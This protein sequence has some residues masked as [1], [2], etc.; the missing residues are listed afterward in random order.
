[1]PYLQFKSPNLFPEQATFFYVH[2]LYSDAINKY[3]PVFLGSMELDIY[4]PS[5]HTGIEFDG[6]NWHQSM[7]SMNG[8]S[9]NINYVKKIM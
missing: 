2:K 6:A 4:I 3:K 7:S 8:T 9:A 1:M 5:I